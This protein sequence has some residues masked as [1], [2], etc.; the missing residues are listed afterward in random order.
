[1][2][3]ILFVEDNL[4]L[5]EDIAELISLRRQDTEIV[6]AVDVPT[7]LAELARQPSDIVVVDIMLPAYPGIPSRD[8]GLYL[9]AWMLGTREKLPESL[10]K[11]T[12]PAAPPVV[13]FLSSLTEAR[14]RS[15]WVKLAGEMRL[16][17]CIGR[18]HDDPDEHY[19]IL[20]R[21]I[22]KVVATRTAEQ[23]GA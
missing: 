15:A 23:A 21:I 1:V 17:V 3:R 18:L 22:E 14:V 19:Q 9:A 20:A 5:I 6:F 16:P 11:W 7:C 12:S 8:E 13:V 4:E 10:K 2:V